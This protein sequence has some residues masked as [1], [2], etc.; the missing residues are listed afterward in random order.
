MLII[1]KRAHFKRR[2]VF[3]PNYILDRYKLKVTATA[4]YSPDTG[5]LAGHAH[6]LMLQHWDH[7][8]K[9]LP[10]VFFPWPHHF[11]DHTHLVLLPS[12]FGHEAWKRT[13]VL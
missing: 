2:T 9:V 13:V 5:I 11:V 8:G 7:T 6:L 3:F 10:R 4:Y 12:M 1:K